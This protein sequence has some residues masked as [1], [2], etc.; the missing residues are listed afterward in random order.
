M[1][2]R[3]GERKAKVGGRVFDNPWMCMFSLRSMR[4]SLMPSH[5][6]EQDTI[7][8]QE[9]LKARF[10]ETYREVAKEYDGEFIKKYDEDLNT[11]L[12]YVSTA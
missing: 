3:N 8:A 2:L 7:P 6:K 10:Y 12:I 1:L 9:D 5:S 4:I 11:T